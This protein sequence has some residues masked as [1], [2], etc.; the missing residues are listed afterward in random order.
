MV[1][2]LSTTERLAEGLV[3]AYSRYNDSDRVFAAHVLFDINVPT[4]R[5]QVQGAE[6]FFAWLKEHSPQGYDIRLLRSVTTASGFVAEIEGEYNP[7]N[8]LYFRNLLLCQ[9]E[10]DRITELV[11]YCTGDWDPETKAR[12]AS[13]APMIRP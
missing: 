10:Q 3:R 2:Q 4:W 5:F 6:A 1:K 11:F 8:G 12:Q 7:S 13:E 9:V